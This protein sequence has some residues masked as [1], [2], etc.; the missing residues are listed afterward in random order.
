MNLNFDLMMALDE[1]LKDHRSMWE[2]LPQNLE[3]FYK[4]LCLIS[5]DELK[6]CSAGGT[7]QEIKAS[8]SLPSLSSGDHKYLLNISW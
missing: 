8:L 7:K 1:K 2:K 6:L 3:H 4:M 5:V